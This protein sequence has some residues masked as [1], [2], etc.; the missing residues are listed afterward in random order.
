M[1]I[2]LGTLLGISTSMYYKKY[3]HLIDSINRYLDGDIDGENLLNFWKKNCP[4]E[5]KNV[6]YQIFHLVSDE[7]IRQRD[8]GYRDYQVDLA[9]KL[10]VLLKNNDSDGL[11]TISLI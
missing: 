10:I 1:H 2:D 9:K 4:T 6:Y 5:I 8:E 3:S 11:K 7:D